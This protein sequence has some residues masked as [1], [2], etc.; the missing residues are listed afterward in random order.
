MTACR[1]L[2]TCSFWQML[3]TCFLTVS[4]ET[5][6]SC[7]ISLFVRCSASCSSTGDLVNPA[8]PPRAPTPPGER[9]G[10]SSPD[11]R[12]NDAPVARPDTFHVQSGGTL[13][14]AAPGI[15]VNDSD[16][17]GDPLVAYPNGTAVTWD[18]ERQQTDDG[19]VVPIGSTRWNL[20][21]GVV[22]GWSI[23]G[24]FMYVAQPGFVGTDE[25]L[26]QARENGPRVTASAPA[27][28]VLIVE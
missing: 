7:A 22:Q 27:K 11:P 24:G 15:L 1:R 2:V 17:D 4:G 19:G 14:I 18:A 16:P 25:F 12:P 5:C 9:G 26:Y 21:G 20:T 3:V 6:S 10:V 23:T 13:V 8:D 28:I